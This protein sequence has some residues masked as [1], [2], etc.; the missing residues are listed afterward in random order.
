LFSAD[1]VIMKSAGI[2]GYYFGKCLDVVP[3]VIVPEPG[4]EGNGEIRQMPGIPAGATVR[5]FSQGLFI[6]FLC[7]I[8]I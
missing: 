5:F 1:T 8:A 7:G 2:H 3:E 6:G 4:G